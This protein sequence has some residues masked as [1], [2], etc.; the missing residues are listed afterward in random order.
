MSESY[1][2][3]RLVDIGKEKNYL[4]IGARN[5][6]LTVNLNQNN[7]VQ[8]TATNWPTTSGLTNKNCSNRVSY[9]EIRSKRLKL[10]IKVKYL[11]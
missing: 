10:S 11:Y 4:I 8:I 9:F 6:L 3:F 5:R 7:D 1:E 2:K